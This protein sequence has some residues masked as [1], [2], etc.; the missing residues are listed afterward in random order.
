MYAHIWAVASGGSYLETVS[1]NLR[2]VPWWG[3]VKMC[4]TKNMSQFVATCSHGLAYRT[5]E[6]KERF[7]KSLEN[8][9][10]YV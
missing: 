6:N 3:H 2:S 1:C 5:G 10:V 8:G 4:P 7:Y 9:L